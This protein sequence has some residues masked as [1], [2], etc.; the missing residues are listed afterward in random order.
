[1][2]QSL[3]ACNLSLYHT[4]K[5]TKS[6]SLARNPETWHAVMFSGSGSRANVNTM[7]SRGSA[8]PEAKE[9]SIE[10]QRY[11][12]AH[13]LSCSGRHTLDTKRPASRILTAAL[14]QTLWHCPPTLV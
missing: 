13:V 3:T 6:A 11:P 14:K 2:W 1:M 8:W 10:A 5:E 4:H 9:L 7:T 12:R